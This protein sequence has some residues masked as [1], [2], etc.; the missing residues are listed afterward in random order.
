MR[1]L[2]FLHSLIKMQTTQN[3]HIGKCSKI[4]T[5]QFPLE[6]IK[7]PHPTT[8]KI[9]AFFLLGTYFQ[10]LLTCAY[11]ES[12]VLSTLLL[13]PWQLGYLYYFQ[14]WQF[15]KVNNQCLTNLG[16]IVVLKGEMFSSMET[17]YDYV[18]YMSTTNFDHL[19]ISVE[20]VKGDGA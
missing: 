16:T 10:D 19:V 8:P 20:Q 1:T 6:I 17:S 4:P 3:L 15:Q 2:K 11:L 9:Y 12:F 14:K 18:C 13:L 7:E 5:N